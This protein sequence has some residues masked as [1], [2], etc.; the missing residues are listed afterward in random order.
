MLKKN[1]KLLN[2]ISLPRENISVKGKA[3]LFKQTQ[4]RENLFKADVGY[5]KS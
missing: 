1:I 3:I 5:E 4:M 2:Q